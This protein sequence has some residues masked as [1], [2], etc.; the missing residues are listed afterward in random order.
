M[1]QP[2][3]WIVKPGE[4]NKRLL[5]FLREK[6][7]CSNREISWSVEHQGCLVNNQTERFG[8]RRLKIGDRVSLCFEERRKI[9]LEEGR[10]LFQDE[11][12]LIYDKPAGFPVERLSEEL[13]YE[14]VHRLD[15]DTTG[16]LILAKSEGLV[17]IFEELFRSRSI[18]KSYLALVQGKPS[19]S[20]GLIENSLA[21][22]EKRQGEVIVGARPPPQGRLA[23]TAWRK[24]A[25]GKGHTLL[26]L[27]PKTG[28]THQ[29]RVH[30][31]G[32]GHPI[33]GDVR[34][35]PRE[36]SG[37]FP[38]TRTLLHAESI[39]FVHPV[40]K[41]L[42]KVAAPLAQDFKEWLTD[43]GIEFKL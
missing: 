20:S 3:V 18:D 34:Y 42:I 11:W 32:I 33:A 37:A 31:Q 16:A 7:D 39:Q 8:S 30:M 40:E 43:L 36:V 13:R 6:L 41:K 14:P 23:I 25:E 9:E 24:I 35:G 28:R 27:N 19:A 22:I 21:V 38:F 10:I 2:Q 29:I 4:E 5:T 12:I 15:R 1:K 17:K 26:R